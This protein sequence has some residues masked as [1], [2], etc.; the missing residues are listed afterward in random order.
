[1]PHHRGCQGYRISI[2]RTTA[3]PGMGTHTAKKHRIVLAVN[4]RVQ[5][6][7]IAMIRPLASPHPAGPSQ[8]PSPYLYAVAGAA[9]VPAQ[10]YEITATGSVPALQALTRRQS[11]YRSITSGRVLNR[12]WEAMPRHCRK[13]AIPFAKNGNEPRLLCYL[14]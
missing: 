2:L 1:M 10:S 8:P 5:I 7:E 13:F 4:I 12:G 11:R 14:R 6:S 3:L 9:T